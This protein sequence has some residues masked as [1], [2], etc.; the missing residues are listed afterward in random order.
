DAY[1]SRD[2]PGA[3]GR[4]RA[5]AA[6]WYLRLGPG[7][8]TGASDDDP[9]GI[10]TYAQAGSQFGF[11]MLWLTVVRLPLLVGVLLAYAH[12]GGGDREGLIA[13]IRRYYG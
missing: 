3:D 6:P 7:L 2:E 12:V 8:L 10:A 1:G 13:A 5:R 4:R 11:A 9:S